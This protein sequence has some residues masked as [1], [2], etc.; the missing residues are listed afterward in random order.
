MKDPTHGKLERLHETQRLAD[1]ASH[2]QI[3]HGELPQHA[4]G[5]DQVT[6]AERDALFL[7]QTSVVARH[8]HIPVCKQRDAQIGPEPA[9]GARLL[10]PGVV[11]VLR[12]GGD[13]CTGR[14]S[15]VGAWA[16]SYR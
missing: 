2:G 6:R 11:R 4:L 5:V 16:H 15:R 10:R 8:A 14:V 1:R 7:N 12:V 13:G 9:L 3:I